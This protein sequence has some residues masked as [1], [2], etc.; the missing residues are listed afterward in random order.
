MK[1][2]GRDGTSDRGGKKAVSKRDEIVVWQVPSQLLS[3]IFTDREIRFLDRF[4]KTFFSGGFL[5]LGNCLGV[6]AVERAGILGSASD[7][8]R[9][10]TAQLE[11]ADGTLSEVKKFTKE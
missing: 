10:T 3:V 7:N 5:L 8:V 2:V 9:F 11:Y 4:A 6:M 1:V